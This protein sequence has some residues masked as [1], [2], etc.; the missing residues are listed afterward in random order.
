MAA[1]LLGVSASA[2]GVPQAEPTLATTS[3]LADQEPPQV[4]PTPA[5]RFPRSRSRPPPPPDTVRLPRH[6][7]H[8]GALVGIRRGAG[9]VQS[10]LAHSTRAA[11][12]PAIAAP[13]DS[14]REATSVAGLG[15]RFPLSTASNRDVD[16]DESSEG[17]RP[18]AATPPP[19]PGPHPPPHCVASATVAPV[20][21]YGVGIREAPAT[22]DQPWYRVADFAS[23]R[24]RGVLQVPNA[25][26]ETE[27]AMHIAL[28]ACAVEPP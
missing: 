13:P 19:V 15:R 22:S 25:C 6:A 14:P 7:P 18:R 1:A 26:R 23:G 17:H 3:A 12:L 21:G 8:G 11:G 10:P 9:A 4:R 16:R 5:P 24:I 27:V 2:F 20:M 28:L